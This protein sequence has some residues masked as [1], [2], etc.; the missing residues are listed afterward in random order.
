M[1][2]SPQHLELR[3]RV[4][5]GELIGPRIYAAGPAVSG[6][7]ARTPEAAAALVQEQQAAG[8]DLLKV[9]TGVSRES[10][11][12][13]AEAAHRL[14]IPFAGH[15]PE[16]VG[17]NRAL[18]ARYSSIDHL[19]SYLQALAGYPDGNAPTPTGLFGF[20]LIDEADEAKIPEVVAATI[21]AGVWNVPTL[22]L[23]E[24]L[25]SPEDPERMAERPE[26][27][28]MPA[29]TVQQW[30]QRK[31]AFQNDA[32][33]T[34]ERGARFIE[35]RRQ[36]VKALHDAGA[37]LALGS[38]APQWWNVPGFSALRELELMVAAGLTPFQ[39]MSA[40]TRD[41]ARLMGA[42]NEWGTIAVGQRADM[43]LLDANPLA[44]ITSVWQRAGV[45]YGGRWLPREELDARL[46][47]IAASNRE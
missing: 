15:V 30:I 41:A 34:P 12:A 8:Y 21:A 46:E 31:R 40:G 10:F 19:D 45:M 25:A 4:A 42:D 23:V 13:M 3:D 11:D 24:H 6:N 37:P 28:Y 35:I 39:A 16:A 29:Q 14:G 7:S 17:L 33:F 20:Y 44:D 2:G 5:A 27:A 1:Q 32:R 26:L 38:D 22:T 18:E 36:L 47:A 43:V 9:Q